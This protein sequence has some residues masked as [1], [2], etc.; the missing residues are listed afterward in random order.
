VRWVNILK[1]G[2]NVGFACIAGLY[3]CWFVQACDITL[4]FGQCAILSAQPPFMVLCVGRHNI[5]PGDDFT[6]IIVTT[7][8]P[9]VS[10]FRPSANLL[11]LCLQ[12]HG[13]RS[14]AGCACIKTGEGCSCSSTGC[15]NAHG[16]QCYCVC[17]V[18]LPSL[19]G[20]SLRN[21]R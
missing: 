6:V 21:R 9:Y 2:V 4:N 3:V 17:A 19:Q 11:K 16:Q 14:S 7:H 10:R 12:H 1:V 13:T 8:A 5:W 15:S 18:S 20:T